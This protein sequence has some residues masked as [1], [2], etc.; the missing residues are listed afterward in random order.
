MFLIFKLNFMYKGIKAGIVLFFILIILL[1]NF[2]LSNIADFLIFQA[3]AGWF[4]MNNRLDDLNVSYDFGTAD[5][6]NYAYAF[7][8]TSSNIPYILWNGYDTASDDMNFFFNKWTPGTGWTQM[9]GTV[10]AD[11]IS[12]TSAPESTMD[13]KLLVYNDLPY[14]FWTVDDGT[15][16]F[17][18]LFVYMTKWTPGTGW[19]NM[20]GTTAGEE[21]LMTIDNTS[22]DDWDVK[23]SSDGNPY[24]V[25]NFNVG[26]GTINFMKWTPNAG[27]GVCGAVT[28]CWTNMAGTDSGYETINARGGYDID[29]SL[30]SQDYPYIVWRNTASLPTYPESANFIRWD[31]SAWTDMSDNLSREVLSYGNYARYP[32]IDINRNDEPCVAWFGYEDGGSDV[33]VIFK[34]WTQGTGWT[35]MDGLSD[36]D[37]VTDYTGG[38]VGTTVLK[39][40]LDNINQSP[41]LFWGDNNT[42]SDNLFFSK[43]TSGI[44]WT[45]MDGNVGYENVTGVTDDNGQIYTA[46]IKVAVD[47]TPYLVW[48]YWDYSTNLQDV[49]ITKYTS[50]VS[51]WTQIDGTAGFENISNTIDTG[52][53]LEPLLAFSSGYFPSVVYTMYDADVKTDYNEDV[54]FGHWQASIDDTVNITATLDPSISLL[55]N[56]NTCALNILTTDTIQTCGF[57]A[58]VT[59][60]IGTGYSGY[61]EQNHPFQT[62]VNAVT[63]VITGPDTDNVINGS[64]PLS[65]AYGEYGIGIKT[66]DTTSFSEFTG[67]CVDYDDGTTDLAANSLVSDETRY[68]FATYDAAVNGVNH[69][70]TYFCAGV[71]IKYTTPPGQ[72]DQTLTISVVGNF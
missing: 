14:I 13:A 21:L 69:G 68:S 37:S 46:D 3:N 50:S 23:M 44:G 8:V 72:Y 66:D 34:K 53:A 55:L 32:R 6:D 40:V 19:T 38:T 1:F 70:L 45:E 43:W 31:G 20:D 30:D 25:K 2:N 51:S 35:S 61:I 42:G 41:Y 56:A 16:Q 64:D 29:M 10:G 54:Y 67:N 26:F 5:W 36:Y 62:T 57:N 71:R 48:D 63:T 49:Y 12:F 60:N 39:M 59:T 17:A 4:D 33:Q 52:M 28:Y 9:D 18:D 47:N 7:E 11:Q 15:G 58:T 65:G 24:V 22:Y 27:T